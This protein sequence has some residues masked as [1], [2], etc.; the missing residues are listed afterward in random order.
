MSEERSLEEMF[1]E[2]LKIYKFVNHTQIVEALNA[3][4]SDD[5]NTK[6]KVYELSDGNRSTRDIQ[7]LV[8]LHRLQ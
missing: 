1:S 5:T 3:E 2:F 6:K 7:K 4:L 8:G